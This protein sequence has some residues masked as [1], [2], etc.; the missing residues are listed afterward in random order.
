[1]GSQVMIGQTNNFIYKEDIK[2]IEFN[3]LHTA[4]CTVHNHIAQKYK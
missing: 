2:W 1:M 4:H 3:T